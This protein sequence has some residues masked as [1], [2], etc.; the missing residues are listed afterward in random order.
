MRRARIVLKAKADSWVEVRDPATKATLLAR[1]LK[2]GDVYEVPDKPG[3]ELLTGNAGGL[4]VMV[5]GQLAPPL[6][7]DGMVRRDIDLSMPTS[8]RSAIDGAG[9]R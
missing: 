7:R 2:S 3:L 1:L 8:L 9:L 5:D 6:G 4:V